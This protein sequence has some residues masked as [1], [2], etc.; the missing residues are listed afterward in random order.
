MVESLEQLEQRAALFPSMGG[1]EIGPFLRKLAREAPA[2]TAIV[3]VGSW[4]GAGTAQLA[5]GVRERG[6]DQSVKMYAYDRWTAS[7]S[8]V[9]KAARKTG[10]QLSR[11]EDTLPL[12]KQALAPFGIDIEFVKGDIAAISWS[13]GPISLYIDDA[14]KQPAR[15]FHVLK[16]FGPSWIPGVTVLVL[17]DYHYWEKSGSELHKCQ[18]YFFDAHRDHFSV[19]EG[20]RRQ[21]IDAFLYC[22][23]LDFERLDYKALLGPAGT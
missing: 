4:L 17:M 1:T 23:K 7:E 2:G 11:G 18:K 15:F 13:A 6:T 16:T 19:V 12:V 10:L 20:F 8:E 3:E 22:K 21:S 14:A 5:L 9:Q